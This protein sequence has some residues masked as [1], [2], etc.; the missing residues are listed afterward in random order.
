MEIKITDMD[1][2]DAN[3]CLSREY[4]T[5]ARATQDKERLLKLLLLANNGITN[6]INQIDS[7]LELTNIKKIKPISNTKK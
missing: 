4:L 6:A 2:I 7:N 3:I 1:I 5:K